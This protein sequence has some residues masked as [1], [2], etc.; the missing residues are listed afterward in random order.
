MDGGGPK[1]QLQQKLQLVKLFFRRVRHELF[2]RFILMHKK[3][4]FLIHGGLVMNQ[5]QQGRQRLS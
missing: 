5:V 3:D 1:K 2:A 4:V